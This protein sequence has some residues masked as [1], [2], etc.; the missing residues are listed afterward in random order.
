MVDSRL[1]GIVRITGQ[2]IILLIWLAVLASSCGNNGMKNAFIVTP[3]LSAIDSMMWQQP[4]SA[5]AV[6][7]EFV[8]SPEADSLNEF[9]GHYCQLLVAELLFKNHYAQSNRA[10]LMAAMGYFDSLVAME[11]RDIPC[12]SAQTA[13]TVFLDARAHYMNGAGYYERDSL[14]EAC[15]EYLRT[16]R[17]MENRF[18]GNEL[19][20]KKARFMALTHNRLMELFSHQFMQ[21]SAIY[22]GKRSLAYDSI[23]HSKP[24]NMAGTLLYIGKQYAKMNEYDSAAYYYDL[25]LNC[26]PDRN[27]VIYRDW[28]AVTAMNQYCA[29]HDTVAALDSLK[30]TIAQSASEG[31]RLNRYLT[32]GA[33]YNDIGQYDSAKF[34]WEPVFEYEKKGFNLRIVSNYLREIALKEGDTLKA[35]QYAQ[36][37]AENSS[38]PGESQAR[39]SQLNEMFQSY[40]QEKQEVASLGERKKAVKTTLLVLLALAMVLGVTT[41][42][43]RCRHRNRLA[44]Q[45]ETAQKRLSETAKELKNQ[46]DEAVQQAHTMLPQRVNDIYHS[47]VSNRME[48]I[49]AE[50]EAAYPHVLEQLTAAYPELNQVEQQIA[51]LNFLR[52]RSKEEADLLGLTESTIFKYRSNLKKKVGSDPISVLI[53]ER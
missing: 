48:R 6:M 17:I 51:V 31:E 34:Y 44:T 26:I 13:T 15:A 40:L 41:I 27:T 11:D 3:Q 37:M 12:A 42:M 23:A 30:S 7:K 8:E 39:V 46:V 4:D 52:F 45:E 14:P 35:D 21:E 9:D 24:I 10:E 20:D 19:V 38:S 22:C 36:V 18:S 5:M 43:M 32:I 49:M 50:F 47:K 1:H 16:L 2:H 53:A 33:I 28:V 25:L 29:Q